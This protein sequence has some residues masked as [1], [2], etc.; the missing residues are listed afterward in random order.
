M[1]GVSAGLPAGVPV[2]DH[3]N[4]GMI[5]KTFSPDRVQQV[6]AEISKTSERDLPAQVMVYYAIAMALYNH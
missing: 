4:L 5:A 3:I 1:A 6:L 2:S